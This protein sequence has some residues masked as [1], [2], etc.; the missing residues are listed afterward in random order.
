M[1]LWDSVFFMGRRFSQMGSVG[2]CLGS[3]AWGHLL[4]CRY[5]GVG[6]G[7]KFS[8]IRKQLDVLNKLK[9]LDVVCQKF[10]IVTDCRGSNKGIGYLQTM[11]L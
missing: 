6:Y 7:V 1:S 2:F 8:V 10:H 9:I 11:A 4:Y 5:L 3:F